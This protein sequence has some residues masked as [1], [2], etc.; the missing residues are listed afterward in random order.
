MKI[1]ECRS[2][3]YWSSENSTWVCPRPQLT[4]ALA[5]RNEVL[6]EF[7]AHKVAATDFTAQ[8]VVTGLQARRIGE[9]PRSLCFFHPSFLVRHLKASPLS[10][11]PSQLDIPSFLPYLIKRDLQGFTIRTNSSR[12]E[13]W[14]QVPSLLNDALKYLQGARLFLICEFL[15][16]FVILFSII[17]LLA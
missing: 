8:R 17:F 6:L 3:L 9:N 5:R 1:V 15:L 14:H 13:I 16:F 2:D 11:S 4:H 10:L 7:M 12:Y